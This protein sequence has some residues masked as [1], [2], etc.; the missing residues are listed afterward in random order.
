[1][2]CG[3]CLYCFKN[4]ILLQ[5]SNSYTRQEDITKKECYILH[6]RYHSRRSGHRKLY[7]LVE[8]ITYISA[9]CQKSALFHVPLLSTAARTPYSWC[10]TTRLDDIHTGSARFACLLG[11][12][13]FFAAR[14]SD[15]E[16]TR[17]TANAALL[18]VHVWLATGAATASAYVL[19]SFTPN[20]DRSTRS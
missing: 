10:T 12:A 7:Y 8:N 19:N 2:L 5:I 9:P 11:C 15:G 4:F 17:K 13:P 6:L 14:T 18:M 16:T 3:R 1:M 20:G